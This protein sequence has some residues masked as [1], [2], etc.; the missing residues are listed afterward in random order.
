MG[1]ERKPWGG[2]FESEQAPLF[3]RLQRFDT[4]RPCP[5]SVRYA[6]GRAL[7]CACLPISASSPRRSATRYSSRSD[8]VAREVE[9]GVFSWRLAG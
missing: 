5:G 6:R 3:E 8:Q 7:T 1:D 2:R 4:L 9:E